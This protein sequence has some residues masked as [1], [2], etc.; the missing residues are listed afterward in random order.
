MMRSRR[1]NRRANIA[2]DFF[3]LP[4]SMLAYAV[5]SHKKLFAGLAAVSLITGGAGYYAYAQQ[6]ITF[7]KNWQ[8]MSAA[9]DAIM[10]YESSRKYGFQVT[11]VYSALYTIEPKNS[12]SGLPYEPE[13]QDE[14]DMQDVWGNKFFVQGNGTDD[15]KLCSS[16][17]RGK[18]GDCE[19]FL[20]LPNKVPLYTE[21]EEQAANADPTPS[22]VGKP[23]KCLDDYPEEPAPQT[24]PSYPKAIK[25]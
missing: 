23:P 5:I 24:A 15:R 8:K 22:D 21:Q 13:L 7:E 16:G 25:R 12:V 14:S 3:L 1:K 6:Q 9:R 11:D 18:A 20:S 17:E 10:D 19:Y 2:K 4:L